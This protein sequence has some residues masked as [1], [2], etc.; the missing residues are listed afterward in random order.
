VDYC[1][2][3]QWN[4]CGGTVIPP[5]YLEYVLINSILICSGN[6]SLTSNHNWG[7]WVGCMEMSYPCFS[8]IIVLYVSYKAKVNYN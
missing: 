7:L 4:V 3:P 2:N 5:Y 1:C 8:I 6:C